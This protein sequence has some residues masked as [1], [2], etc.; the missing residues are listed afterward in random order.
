MP[1]PIG[2]LAFSAARLAVP[3][4]AGL[5]AT[6]D[7]HSLTS[8]HASIEGSH[9]RSRIEL[10]SEPRERLA[11]ILETDYRAL[12]RSEQCERHLPFCSRFFLPLRRLPSRET[13]RP[14]LSVPGQLQPPTRQT[15]SKAAP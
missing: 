10:N 14:S 13:A 7:R 9:A 4:T 12:Q 1:S 15:S 2:A 8:H 6:T 5:R 11:G 3:I